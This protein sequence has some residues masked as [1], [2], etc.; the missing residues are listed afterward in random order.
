M[1]SGLT[2]EEAGSLLAQKTRQVIY[3]PLRNMKDLE[4]ENVFIIVPII[5]VSFFILIE[6]GHLLPNEPGDKETELNVT[7]LCKK[8]CAKNTNLICTNSWKGRGYYGINMDFT[9]NS[10]DK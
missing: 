5:N 7:Y 8:N 6:I 10:G 1:H 3:E 9:L 2:L 4:T